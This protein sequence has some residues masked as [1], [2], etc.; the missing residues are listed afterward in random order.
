MIPDLKKRVT[1][2]EKLSLVMFLLVHDLP[3]GESIALHKNAM[4][5]LA[6]YDAAET[7]RKIRDIM[8][9][10]TFAEYAMFPAKGKN[11]SQKLSD[12][13]KV[14]YIC[15]CLALGMH[16]GGKFMKTVMSR[17]SDCNATFFIHHLNNIMKYKTW[18][19]FAESNFFSQAYDCWLKQLKG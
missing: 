5:K 8:K 7:L 10:R 6:K 18:N 13:D 15:Y 16:G 3:P 9:C 2:S 14:K 12:L 19:D 1:D 17:I 4:S 11:T